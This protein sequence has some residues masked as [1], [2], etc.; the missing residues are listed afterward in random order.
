MSGLRKCFFEIPIYRC[1]QNQHTK[2]I[3]E[4]RKNYIANRFQFAPELS[5]EINKQIRTSAENDFNIHLWYPWRYNEVVGWIRLCAD[6]T[7]IV[8]ELWY[9]KAKTIRRRLVKKEFL[10]ITMKIIELNV[11]SNDSSKE[12]FN[13][14]STELEQLN[15][16]RLLKKRY[17]D[18]DI[19]KTIGPFIDWCQL[20][21]G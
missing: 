16:I 20:L 4:E 6:G 18:I 17:I 2:E 15:S 8:G 3:E 7:R 11:H 14:I 5:Q 13:K 9:I 12:I 10:C 19:F 1:D 21:A